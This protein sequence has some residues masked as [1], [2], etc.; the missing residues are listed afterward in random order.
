MRSAFVGFSTPAGYCY[1]ASS[2]KLANSDSS[3]NPVLVGGLGLLILYDE[4]WFAC[5][6]LCPENMRHL[7]YVKFL[8]REYANLSFGDEAFQKEASALEKIL[9]SAQSDVYDIGQP[10]PLQDEREKFAE[11]LCDNHSHAI[12]TLG[13]SFG[14]NASYDNLAIDLAIISRF[15]NK[16][17]SIVLNEATSAS[18]INP[19]PKSKLLPAIGDI[20]S[21]TESI[22]HLA[23][24]PE[25]VDPRGPYHPV[26]EELRDDKLVVNFRE[27]MDSQ[28]GSL[29]NQDSSMV[30]SDVDA[31][32]K[33]FEQRSYRKY[34]AGKPTSDR[35]YELI[36]DKIIKTVPGLSD[37]MKWMKGARD[38]AEA[39]ELRWQAFVALSRSRIS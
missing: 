25:M 1:G 6:N 23:G 27:W 26:I 38:E 3:P 13:S 8:D 15:K 5:E 24:L 34:V 37:A 16:D 7:K 19:S 32:I 39:A 29:S 35:V 9:S 4:V 22:L 20:T 10:H 17:F 11:F 2:P 33:D 18:F 14:G 30:L 36:R 21:L 12:N 31:K 28:T